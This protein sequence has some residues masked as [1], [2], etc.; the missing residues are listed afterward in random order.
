MTP[1]EQKIFDE[2]TDEHE[3]EHA[4]QAALKAKERF[5]FFDFVEGSF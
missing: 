3:K 4:R 2:A 1:E 5:D